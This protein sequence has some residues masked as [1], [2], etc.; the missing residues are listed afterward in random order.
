MQKNKINT[1][2]GPNGSG[3][4]TLLEIFG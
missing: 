4:S 3:K 1:I 2:V